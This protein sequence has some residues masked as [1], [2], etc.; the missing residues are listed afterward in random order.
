LTDDFLDFGDL[1]SN[2]LDILVNDFD[3][4]YIFPQA[5][6]EMAR[7]D[8]GYAEVGIDNAMRGTFWMMFT[9]ITDEAEVANRKVGYDLA[10]VLK[11]FDVLYRQ[12]DINYKMMVNSSHTSW[13]PAKAMFNDM[14]QVG[15]S[16]FNGFANPANFGPHRWAFRKNGAS[17]TVV[18]GMRV[19]NSTGITRSTTDPVVSLALD[20]L[21]R[22]EVIDTTAGFSLDQLGTYLRY[23]LMFVART[24][25]YDHH[26]AYPAIFTNIKRLRDNIRV[27][28]QTVNQSTERT[29]IDSL[30]V[31]TGDLYDQFL[32]TTEDL[33]TLTNTTEEFDARIPRRNQHMFYPIGTHEERRAVV[34][35]MLSSVRTSGGSGSSNESSDAMEDV[36]DE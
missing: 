23:R 8:F 25:A 3:K 4:K 29:A 13:S 1:D 21:D 24:Y 5:A 14:V 18:K 31:S 35:A 30:V 6:L 10:L 28:I 22:N 36:D 26:D 7:N 33:A 34:T 17:T 9:T 16:D 12:I 2:V 19:Y 27:G 20:V 11:M 32:V 15:I